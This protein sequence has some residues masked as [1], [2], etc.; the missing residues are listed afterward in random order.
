VETT[1]DSGISL[2][3]ASELIGGIETCFTD[4]D[5]VVL[6]RS[7]S[8]PVDFQTQDQVYQSDRRIAK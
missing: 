1:T 4:L 8:P 5:T 6:D 7:S 3:K 2:H